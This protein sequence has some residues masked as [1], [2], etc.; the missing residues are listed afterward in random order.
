MA[1]ARRQRRDPGAI[2]LGFLR[3]A[4]L[5]ARR[6]LQVERMDMVAPAA[7]SGPADAPA[8]PTRPVS[9]RAIPR[10]LHLDDPERLA[11]YRRAVNGQ[12][13]G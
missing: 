10:L 5:E 12:L 6:S 4:A 13:S 1:D 9:R 3:D 7:R 11:L 8:G 2:S